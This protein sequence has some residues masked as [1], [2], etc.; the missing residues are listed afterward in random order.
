MKSPI[1]I[2]KLNSDGQEVF[3]YQGEILE[4]SERQLIVQ[5]I[6]NHRDQDVVGLQLAHGDVFIE[7][8][9][10][11]RWYNIFAVLTKDLKRIKGWYCNITR[12]ARIEISDIYADDL[13][14]DVIIDPSGEFILV[15]EQEFEDLALPAA[16]RAQA[17]R[18][19]ADIERLASNATG[20]FADVKRFLSV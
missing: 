12:P 14:L 4:R 20:P 7:Y 19:V 10:E 9:F 2:H 3:R 15:D 18:A 11:K 6:Y 5:A 17:R 1:T 13:A 16:E 8:H